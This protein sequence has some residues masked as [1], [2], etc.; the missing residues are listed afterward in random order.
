MNVLPNPVSVTGRT[1]KIPRR[2]GR[3]SADGCR[4]HPEGSEGLRVMIW[5]LNLGPPETDLG[6]GIQ[7]QWFVTK[8]RSAD[9]KPLR[10]S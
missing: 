5:V 9:C 6:A 1:V 2:W 7:C 3:G 4:G 8:M 10:M